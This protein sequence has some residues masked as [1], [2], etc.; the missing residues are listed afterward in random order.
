MLDTH[1]L[2]SSSASFLVHTRTCHERGEAPLS[3]SGTDPPARPRFYQALPLGFD[4]HRA[5]TASYTA[6]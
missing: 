5:R 6:S 3:R 2:R 1:A 4:P